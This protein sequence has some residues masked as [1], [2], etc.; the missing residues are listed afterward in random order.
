MLE[1]MVKLLFGVAV[2]LSTFLSGAALAQDFSADMV[3]TTKDGTFTGKIFVSKDKTRV[4]VPESVTITRM[5]KKVMWMLMPSEK[6]Y[7]EQPFDPRNVT[8]TSEGVSGEIE[9]KLIGQ[10]TVNGKIASKYKVTYEVEGVRDAVFQW[11]DTASS[12][13]VKTEAADGSWTME[14]KNLKIGAQPD[15][16]FEIPAGYQKFSYEMPTVE[17]MPQE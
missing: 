6:M 4:E 14:Y 16:L 10:E 8:A 3:S 15:S 2:I 5:D 17:G 7:M 11:I 12:I 1:K 13:P 9:R